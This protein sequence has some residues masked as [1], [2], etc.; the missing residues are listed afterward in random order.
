MVVDAE[1]QTFD[2]YVQGGAYATQTQFVTNSAYRNAKAEINRLTINANAGMVTGSTFDVDN[3]FVDTTSENLNVPEGAPPTTFADAGDGT[4]ANAANWDNGVPTTTIDAV[5]N[6]NQTADLAGTT[7]AAQNLGVGTADGESAIVNNGSLD[8]LRS[9][10]IGSGV[11]SSGTVSTVSFDTAGLAL[12]TGKSA[13]GK[14]A[15]TSLALNIPSANM[16]TGSNSVGVIEVTTGTIVAESINL[17]T[18]Q[19]ST[20]TAT[21]PTGAFVL[22]ATNNLFVG[23]G[24]GSSHNLVADAFAI[25]GPIGDFGVGEGTGASI[26]SLFS[27]NDTFGS[28]TANAALELT[29]GTHTM[30]AL[31]IADQAGSTG[32]LTLSGSATASLSG[33]LRIAGGT[34]STGTLTDSILKEAGF[35]SIAGGTDASGTATLGLTNVSANVEVTFGAGSTATVA[36]L[37]DLRCARLTMGDGADSVASLTSEHAINSSRLRLAFASNSTA[38]VSASTYNV[39]A[40]GWLQMARGADSYAKVTASDGTIIASR[41]LIATGANAEAILAVTNG[42]F[43][44]ASLA[45]SNAVNTIQIATGSNSTATVLFANIITDGTNDVFIGTG[46]NATASVVFG[47]GELVAK[48]L[49]LG[50][51]VGGTGTLEMGGDLV[52]TGAVTIATG[53]YIDIPTGASFTWAGKTEADFIVLWDAGALRSG[54]TTGPENAFSDYFQISGDTVSAGSVGSISISGPVAG[55]MQISWNSFA[56]QTYIIQYKN[57]LVIDPNWGDIIT[58]IGIGGTQTVSVPADGTVKFYQVISPTE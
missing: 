46:T 50:N 3:I 29:A 32:S 36:L 38:T 34:G 35:V 24:V 26:T 11:A 14:L 45:S 20:L 4:W 55:E 28:I 53:S 42:T 22:N 33:D 57:N 31:R 43:N 51:A 19:D 1:N 27:A 40:A 7:G 23:T 5:V 56:G 58:V 48:D 2:G 39:Y 49:A 15:S 8:I 16:A 21:L 37:D 9:T 54:G 30:T 6:G 18:G 10:T 47:A 13:Y 25:T 17:A 52:V 44:I 41:M 12:A